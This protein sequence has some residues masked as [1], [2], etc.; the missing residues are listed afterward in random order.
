MKRRGRWVDGVGYALR[1][2]VARRSKGG[3]QG[4]LQRL[5]GRKIVE[6]PTTRSALH[7]EDERTF[8]AKPYRLSMPGQGP[9]KEALGAE[10][11]SLASSDLGGG[12]GSRHSR[13][14]PRHSWVA[15]SV[16]SSLPARPRSRGAVWRGPVPRRRELGPA[17]TGHRRDGTP[18]PSVG[19][20]RCTGSIGAGVVMST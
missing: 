9:R 8:P 17:P 4:L 11:R 20:R 2:V 7:I 12:S 5:R 16:G 15:A 1:A 3:T 18:S 19:A 6:G 13:R 10:R 14:C